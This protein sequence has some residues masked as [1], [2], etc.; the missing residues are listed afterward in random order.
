[1]QPRSDC[2][3]RLLMGLTEG[4]SRPNGIYEFRKA[5]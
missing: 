3:N 4:V 2:V 5:V 1:M